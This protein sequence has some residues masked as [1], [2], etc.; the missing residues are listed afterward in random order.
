M[1]CVVADVLKFFNVEF[2]LFSVAQSYTTFKSFC[3]LSQSV[4][5]STDLYSLVSSPKLDT[6]EYVT[7]GFVSAIIE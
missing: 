3:R 7:S 6:D 4:G 2:I 5:H 1:F